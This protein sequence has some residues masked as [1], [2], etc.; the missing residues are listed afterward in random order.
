MRRGGWMAGL[1]LFAAVTAGAQQWTAPTAEELSMTSQ[2]GA[3][4]AP[5][6]FLY[7]EQVADDSLHMFGYY[8]RLKVLTEGGKDQ[9]NVELPFVVNTLGAQIDNIAGRTIHPDGTIIPF[10]GKP[11]DKLI[12]KAQGYKI[13]AKVFTLPSVEVGSILEYRYKLHYDD[14]YVESPDWYV[15]SDL[16]L[17]KAH[18]TWRP[19][20]R[21]ISNE[22]EGALGRIAWTPILP[23]GAQVKQSNLMG[24]SGGI[25]LDLD[26][27]DIPPL[28]HEA[29][30][31]P[32]DSLSYRVMFY[33]TSTTGQ[34]EYWKKAG[35]RWSK[36][37]DTFVGPGKGVKEFVQQTVAANDTQEQKL[38]KLYDAVMK[39]ENTD[40]TRERTTQEE[41]A[42]GL[43]QVTTSDDIL[44]RER[45]S[46]NQL[47]ELFVAMARA[48][49][50]KAYVMGV[51]DRERRFFIPTYLSLS[52][53]DDDI[54]I[55]NVD[56]KDEYFDPGERY[57]EFGHL[58][59]KHAGSA[60]LR[61]TEG[62]TAL[63]PSQS[64]SYKAAHVT[65]I[66]DLALDEQG[67]AKGT[68]KV[69][70]TGD[71]A[72]HW[73]QEAL[74]GDDTSLNGDLR[75]NMEHLL[76]GG[77]EVRVTNV[78]NLADYD[79][80]LQVDY[81]VKGAIGAPTG[82]RLL[83][84]ANLF[85]VNTKPTFPE[86]KREQVVYM[87]YPSYFQ[88]AV[89]IKYPPTMAIESAPQT[90]TDKMQNF[91]LY[92]TSSKQAPGSITTY[93]NMQMGNVLYEVKEYPELR[94][95][96]GKLETKDQEPVI[97]TRV[98]PGTAASATVPAV[99]GK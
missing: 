79:K 93:R 8:V 63:V 43:K 60:G 47:A 11:Y 56:G 95:F 13:K 48:A 40:L 57:C 15:Q 24:S 18:Y 21:D 52:Q 23:P 74:R 59:W 46:S 53:L 71:P 44:K 98:A 38:K 41:K 85:E 39:L 76:P 90:E 17:R 14:A 16:Y 80:P 86:S 66:A 35:K 20:T 26:V 7:K 29:F 68:V 30:M 42:A 54:A 3:P 61:Q 6:V 31:P 58:S 97:L 87:H 10:T 28:V 88:D 50:M 82:K 2:A 32:A 91:I 19:S 12:E 1:G 36:K 94:A 4:G 55:V 25:Q 37:Q 84:Q 5:A 77:M 92:T 70:Y 73:R 49:G 27:H 64:E 96:Y 72:L 9:A 99:P 33:W 75:T 78:S 65:R 89:R 45:G 62:G 83:I 69:T 81:E 34:D 51:A 67:E 22:E